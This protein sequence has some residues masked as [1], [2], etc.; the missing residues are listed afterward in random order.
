MT[1][2]R[3]ECC[4]IEVRFREY[5]RIAA[6]DAYDAAE[7]WSMD[8]S[9]CERSEVLSEILVARALL[10]MVREV[11]GDSYSK[12]CCGVDLAQLSLVQAAVAG[13]DDGSKPVLPLFGA[14]FVGDL[15]FDSDQRRM[16]PTDGPADGAD[17]PEGFR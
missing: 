6:G 1:L 4:D 8:P 11:V 3:D 2:V 13:G 15:Q 9:S 12:T 7:R 10:G 17:V 5:A 14:V 16:H